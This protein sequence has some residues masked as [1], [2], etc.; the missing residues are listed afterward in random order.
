MF[1]VKILKVLKKDV[2]TSKAGG[3]YYSFKLLL[4]NPF[5]TDDQAVMPSTKVV[6]ASSKVEIPSDDK[7]RMV[8]VSINKQGQMWIN[9]LG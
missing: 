4:D 1:L 8:Y 2:K 3:Q 6:W 5:F 9:G 7:I